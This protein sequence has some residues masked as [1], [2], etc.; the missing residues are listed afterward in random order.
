MLENV[1]DPKSY[2]EAVG[3]QDGKAWLG[4][5]A[6]EIDNL[7]RRNVAI[8]V[9]RPD[10]SIRLLGIKYVFKTKFKHGMV[11]KRNVRIVAK[12]YRQIKDVDYSETFVPV[13][14]M[15]TFRFFLAISVYRGHTR[16][17]I[18]YVAAFLYAPVVE[19]IYIETPEGWDVGEGN[20]LKLNK[21][22]YGLKQAGRNWYQVLKDF[23]EKEGLKM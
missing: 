20:V 2:R 5:I 14:R 12:G 22:L 21:A 9:K 1:I 10:C 6:N 7:K 8:E 23:L 3:S 18:D 11:D 13:A 17:Q 4:A 15:N 16:I 19:D